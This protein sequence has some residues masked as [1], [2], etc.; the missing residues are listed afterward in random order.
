MT[1]P[2]QVVE[3]AF[4][5]NPFDPNAVYTDISAYVIGI[6]GLSH[7]RQNEIGRFEAGGLTLTLNNADRRFD[8]TFAAGPYYGNL[9][10]MVRIRITE[11][12]EVIGVRFVE[13]WA[14]TFELSAEC[15]VT[16]FDGLKALNQL[17]VI[18]YTVARDSFDRAA[19]AGLGTAD[20]GGAW[21]FG[22]QFGDARLDGAAAQMRFT[23]LAADDLTTSVSLPGLGSA[24]ASGQPWV[25]NGGAFARSVNGAIYDSL[26]LTDDVLNLTTLNTAYSN[27]RL[28]VSLATAPAGVIR[29]YVVFRYQDPSH[30][31]YVRCERT[32]GAALFVYLGYRNGAGDLDLFGTAYNW[33]GGL[34]IYLDTNIAI[35]D[36]AGTLLGSWTA[37]TYLSSAT[38]IGLGGYFSSLATSPTYT[39]VMAATA[40]TFYGPFVEDNLDQGTV[41]GALGNAV[42][43]G[44]PWTVHTGAFQRNTGAGGANFEATV[45]PYVEAL[46]TLDAGYSDGVFH[47]Y[48]SGWAGSGSGSTGEVRAIFRYQDSNNFWYVRIRSAVSTTTYDL[49]QR[50]LG[51]E[52]TI[53]TASVAFIQ[54]DISVV[55]I[56]TAIYVYRA[57]Y[58]LL[59]S[60]G[61]GSMA[62]ATRYGFGGQSASSGPFP[63]PIRTYDITFQRLLVSDNLTTTVAGSL[64]NASVTGQAWTIHAG[65]FRR[66]GNGAVYETGG[67]DNLATI[68]TNNADG[69]LI[70]KWAVVPGAST[71]R[72]FII[73]RFSDVN[74]FWYL[75]FHSTAASMALVKR[76]AGVDTTV[77][78]GA[79]TFSPPII[80]LNGS[81]IKVYD[82][83]GTLRF[84]TVDTF[85]QVATRIGFGGAVTTFTGVAALVDLNFFKQP[86]ATI[87]T[88]ASDCGVSF[89]QPVAVA[90]GGN[91]GSVAPRLIFRYTD[92][93][94]YLFLQV[95]ALSPYSVILGKVVNGHPFL[96]G[97]NITVDA[98]G[99]AAYGDA[100]GG[101]SYTVMLAANAIALTV[102]YW[103]S[104]AGVPTQT[105]VTDSRTDSF[106]QTATQHG[107]GVTANDVAGATGP[108]LLT[109]TAYYGFDD[110]SVW[111]GRPA[112]RSGS[113]I[114]G[115]LNWAGWGTERNIAVGDFLTT[116]IATPATPIVNTDNLLTLIQ[117][118]VDAEGGRFYINRKNIATFEDQSSRSLNARSNTIQATFGPANGEIHYA[119]GQPYLDD[120][121]LVN[122]IEATGASGTKIVIQDGASRAR[123]LDYPKTRAYSS[124]TDDEAR[125]LAQLEVGRYSAPQTR[126]DSLDPVPDVD[127]NLAA[128]ATLEVS[129]LVMVN[130]QPPDGTAVVAF[131]SYVEH[132]EHTLDP[133][134][135]WQ[136]QLR[137]S[138]ANLSNFLVLDNAVLGKLDANRFGTFNGTFTLDSPNFGVLDFRVLG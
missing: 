53:A 78:S 48:G 26:T 120:S 50:L 47:Y 97:A 126:V 93:L 92:P 94:N 43:S 112:E 124:A 18:D 36:L 98:A 113:R 4:G 38:V 57:G 45:A 7:G 87:D 60:T 134:E 10:P 137:L 3:A 71:Y 111:T 64:G 21:A 55:L 117:A 89:R 76:V 41:N 49:I 103:K 74:N 44:Q 84:S 85:N 115:L 13:R 114:N 33:T 102:N 135:T 6:E 1:W 79:Y 101:N 80:Y 29:G 105:T 15:V 61:S 100:Y 20:K 39:G 2:T 5:Y 62:T 91:G 73:F 82:D 107:I 23:P 95:N 42:P 122:L 25:N 72:G 8:P 121:G 67:V 70:P 24:T 118:A 129:D 81:A 40:L 119:N 116:A 75:Q 35:L 17:S 138:P 12:G 63:N 136:P 133:G 9:V 46:A 83:G 69:I 77:A 59:F 88:G 14:P 96:L 131:P 16:A 32:A 27:G 11:G 130:Y 68:E 109:P 30:F 28:R 31:W 128:Y 106:N 58:V 127:A 51:V 37:P 123:F 65:S 104:V 132:V 66:T 110:F 56:G 86:A 99:D 34:E 108:A 19:G 125:A 22:G 54:A 90:G 52:T